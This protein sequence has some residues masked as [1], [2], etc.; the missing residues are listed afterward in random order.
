MSV[1]KTL[2]ISNALCLLGHAPIQS[3]D[4]PDDLTVAAEQAF[5]LLLPNIL[6]NNN[7][8]FAT[9]IA[10]LSQSTE[11]PPEPWKT[12][13]NLP[14]GY[15]K[16]I[17]LYP[18]NYAYQ[19][20]QNKRLY[21]YADGKLSMEYIFQPEIA[22]LPPRFNVYFVHEIALYLCLS[23]AQKPEYYG[24]LKQERDKTFAMALATEAQNRPQFSQVDFPVLDA[25]YANDGFDGN[26]SS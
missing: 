1:T 20:Y 19:I 25:R 12:I 23:N 4:D 3:L 18:Q 6:S 24:T 15:L 26:V 17:R 13:Y 5:N 10:Q 8:R 14:A 2:L 22:Y 9:Q 16:L 21:S 11:V 7:W